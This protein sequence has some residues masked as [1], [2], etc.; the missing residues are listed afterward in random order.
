ML[1]EIALRAQRMG[2]KGADMRTAILDAGT[3]RAHDDRPGAPGVPDGL[4]GFGNGAIRAAAVAGPGRSGVPSRR[5]RRSIHL[6]QRWI[7]QIKG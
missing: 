2:I 6:R 4:E 7:W 5:H 3:A 1:D